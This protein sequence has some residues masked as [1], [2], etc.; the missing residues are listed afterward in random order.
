MTALDLRRLPATVPVPHVESVLA[1]DY[2]VD[3][4]FQQAVHHRTRRVRAVGV[5]GRHDRRRARSA[6]STRRQQPLR[7][8]GDGDIAGINLR[9]FGDGLDVA[10]LQDPR[11]A[12]TVSGRF[13]VDGA[14]S[15]AARWR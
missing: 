13:R 9:R 3:G 4:T 10:W 7:Y 6:R 11:Y 8:T 2:D 1:F 5:S 15:S 14:G 12:G